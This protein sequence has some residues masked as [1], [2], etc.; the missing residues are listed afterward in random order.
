LWEFSPTSFPIPLT[1]ETSA[2]APLKTAGFGTTLLRRERGRIDRFEK[3]EET[4]LLILSIGP[5]AI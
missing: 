3:Q 1:P 4:A 2:C 5:T